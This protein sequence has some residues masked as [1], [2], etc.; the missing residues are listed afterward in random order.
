MESITATINFLNKTTSSFNFS[1]QSSGADRLPRIVLQYMNDVSSLRQILTY[2]VLPA[3]IA[4]YPVLSSLL[5]FRRVRQ[6]HRQYPYATRESMSRMTDRE[7][8]EIQ[9]EIAQ[10]EF[11]FI[12]VKA[13]QFALFRVS[14]E[15]F[16]PPGTVVTIII[17]IIMKIPRQVMN[18]I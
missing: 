4:A 14:S 1:P 16:P 5:R 17:I 10:L 6:L 8:W 12:F 2:L 11:P 3:V 13:L 9:K 7:A 15:R 18:T